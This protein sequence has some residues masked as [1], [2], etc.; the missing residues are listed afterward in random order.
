MKS[1]PQRLAYLTN[2]PLPP[3]PNIIG[4]HSIN[5]SWKEE[6]KRGIFLMNQQFHYHEINAK[7]GLWEYIK[8]NL[9]PA[10]GF[11]II[12]GCSICT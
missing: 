9:I 11:S 4:N 1:D 7:K 5:H 6:G 2:L 3:S 10:S 8:G 12:Q